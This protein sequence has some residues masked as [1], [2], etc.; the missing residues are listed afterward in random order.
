[1]KKT[2]TERG[3][4]HCDRS[5]TTLAR[6]CEARFRSLKCPQPELRGR[7]A[8]GQASTSPKVPKRCSYR[9][10]SSA[11]CQLRHRRRVPKWIATNFRRCHLRRHP[12][13]RLLR[14]AFRASPYRRGVASSRITAGTGR[15]IARQPFHRTR[16]RSTH[17]RL[18][19]WMP[20]SASRIAT[21]RFRC[22]R[23]GRQAAH[24]RLICRRVHHH[25]GV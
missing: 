16:H 6:C 14:T 19:R 3:P 12:R 22:H 7:S 18:A 4:H 20:A 1:M 11:R 5:R 10:S 24:F 25:V 23:Q 8:S 9:S 17:S 21:G 15:S 13:N 2:A